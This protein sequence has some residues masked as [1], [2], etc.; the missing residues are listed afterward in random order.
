M[1]KPQP[2]Q[3]QRSDSMIDKHRL[4]MLASAA[5]MSLALGQASAE[6]PAPQAA[7]ETTQQPAAAPAAAP[8]EAATGAEAMRAKM[9]QRHAE[10]M[11]ERD[12]RY[13]ELRQ[14]AAEVGLELPET[15]PWAQ[16]GM[17]DMPTPPAMLGDP[18]SRPAPMAPK[19]AETM[20]P[21]E[22]QAMREERWEAMRAR[23]AERGMELP[24]TPPWEAAEQR[25]KERLERYEQYRAIIEAMT[26]EQKEAISALFNNACRPMPPQ[27]MPYYRHPHGYRPMRPGMGPDMQQGAPDLEP[28]MMLPPP[29][30]APVTAPTPEP[31]G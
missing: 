21:E 26:D 8:A 4:L 2:R 20:T 5:T 19:L 9:Q 24:E 1:P 10:A 25:R 16:Q 3:L 11:A 7:P 14:R 27:A 18:M 28:D 23:A 13:V 30:P 6:T 29:P 12:K 17:P 22:L 15:P 31:A